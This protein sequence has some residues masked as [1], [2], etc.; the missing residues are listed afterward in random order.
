MEQVGQSCSAFETS[1]IVCMM[2]LNQALAR[3]AGSRK[4][5][6]VQEQET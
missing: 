1:E 2:V 4:H 5:S 3:E 6:Q